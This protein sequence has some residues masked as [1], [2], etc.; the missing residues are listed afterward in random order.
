V[1][2]TQS[3]NL[4]RALDRALTTTNWPDRFQRV[5]CDSAWLRTKL[6]QAGLRIV[7]RDERASPAIV[8]VALPETLETVAVA[9]AL[10]ARG[11]VTSTH[12]Q[13]LLTRNWLQICLMG[14]VSRRSLEGVA[15][16]L[17]EICGTPSRHTSS[18]C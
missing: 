11:F 8:T 5:A 4:V 12:S 3:S 17:V 7:G 15:Q 1:P 18:S 13:Y 10:A 2:F 6:R 9:A 14:E 16:A